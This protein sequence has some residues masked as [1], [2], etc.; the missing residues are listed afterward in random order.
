MIKHH[1]KSVRLAHDDPRAGVLRFSWA[2]TL[3]VETLHVMCTDAGAVR[4]RLLAIDPEFM[5]LKPEDF[6]EEEDVREHFIRFQSLVHHL[7]TPRQEINSAGP[8][9]D[10]PS[11]E[12]SEQMAQLLWEIHRDFSRFMQGDA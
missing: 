9:R 7:E 4:E 2:Y 6:P 11:S 10:R 3:T 12:A 1:P 8:N 5:K